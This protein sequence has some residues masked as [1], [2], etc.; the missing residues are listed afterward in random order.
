MQKKKGDVPIK[1]STISGFYKKKSIYF[2]LEASFGVLWFST[3]PAEYSPFHQK[4]F[5]WINW[6]Y[7]IDLSCLQASELFGAVF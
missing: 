3:V 6:E 5:C 4:A 2:Y 7:T 1:N